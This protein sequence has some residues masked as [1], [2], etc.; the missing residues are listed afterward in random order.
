MYDFSSKNPKTM[1]K[2]PSRGMKSIF[3]ILDGVE[4]LHVEVSHWLVPDD[5]G[6]VT[7]IEC[8]QLCNFPQLCNDN[9]V[10]F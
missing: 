6:P 7:Y 4:L 1:L 9:I 10:A 2:T 8:T 5:T 3:V